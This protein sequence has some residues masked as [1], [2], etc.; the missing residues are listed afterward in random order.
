MYL[1]F[2]IKSIYVIKIYEV[3][4]SKLNWWRALLL[5]NEW[6]GGIETAVIV[7]RLESCS[8]SLRSR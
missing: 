3:G 4:T 8:K 1:P 6:L 5:N 7:T 2:N